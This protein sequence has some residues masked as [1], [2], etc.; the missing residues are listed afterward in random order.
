LSV[1]GQFIASNFWFMAYYRKPLNDNVDNH[2]VIV[3]QILYIVK[4]LRN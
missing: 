4:K 2:Y 1:I 3:A